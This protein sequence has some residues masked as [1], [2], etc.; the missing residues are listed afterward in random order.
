MWAQLSGGVVDRI[1]THPE[2]LKIS[3][4]TY[5]R[6]TFTD[7]KKL[8]SLNIIPY[9]EDLV[10]NRYYDNGVI[11][12]EV[13]EDEVYGKYTDPQEKDFLLIKEEMIRKTQYHVS[14]LLSRD[15]WMT[16]RAAEYGKSMPDNYVNYRK[17]LRKES[18]DKVNE[19]NALADLDGVMLY[20]NTPYT[21]VNKV[22][23]HNP[24]ANV[25]Y[26]YGPD[27]I[28]RTI[29]VDETYNYVSVDPLAKED[30]IFVS[31]TKK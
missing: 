16:I 23:H 13:K 9:R 6:Q 24:T 28:E 22:V 21:Q 19:I 12:Y 27:T 20:Q 7:A 17:A 2:I 15:D 5:P 3:G 10:D 14:S 18:N 30:P 25:K 26:T 31:L 8:K 11:T 4:V 29:Y 1:I